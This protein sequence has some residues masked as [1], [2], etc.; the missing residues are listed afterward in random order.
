MSGLAGYISPDTGR[1]L[2]FAI[3]AADAPRRAALAMA[4]REA[5]EGGEGWNRRARNL[6]QGLI[7]RWVALY[8]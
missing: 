2:C 3:F 8:A 5:P 6:H 7:R 4:D 1:E